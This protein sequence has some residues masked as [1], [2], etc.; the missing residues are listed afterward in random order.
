MKQI[1]NKLPVVAFAIGITAAF[2]F[3][4]PKTLTYHPVYNASGQITSWQLVSG[5]YHCNENPN[6]ICT[7]T[8]LNDDPKK[9]MLTS[10]PG[11]FAQP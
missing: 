10:V 4:A 5:S 9:Q 6:R 1:K 3:K 8:F 7:A 11:D 2:A